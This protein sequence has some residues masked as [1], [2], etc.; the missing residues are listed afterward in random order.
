MTQLQVQ[1][2]TKQTQHA[3]DSGPLRVPF[4][5]DRAGLSEIVNMLLGYDAPL[6]FE[7]MVLGHHLTSTLSQSIDHLNLST[8]NTTKTTYR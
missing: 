7:F 2:T 6:H 3:I 8:V 5:I 1:L 4:G